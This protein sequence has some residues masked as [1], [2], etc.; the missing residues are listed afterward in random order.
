MNLLLKLAQIYIPSF[1]KKRKLL[2]LFEITTQA[3][4][5]DAPDVKGLSFDKCLIEYARFT[6]TKAEAAIRQDQ[7]LEILKDRLYQN[8][9]QL[10]QQL[11][12]DFRI[13][14][15]EDVMTMSKILYQILGIEFQGNLTG[16]VVIKSC[17]FSRFYS[18]QVCQL[19]SSLD[20]GVAAGLSGGGKLRFY[21][22]ITEGH[23]C[24]KAHF[25][26]KETQK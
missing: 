22:Q 26:L 17:F 6:Q 21:Q 2:K 18:S 25:I 20:E 14:S 3:F 4:Q 5:C 8:A 16:E 24:C 7:N 9:Y 12:K 23:D 11:R 10:G 15:L 1:I 19:I 13:A